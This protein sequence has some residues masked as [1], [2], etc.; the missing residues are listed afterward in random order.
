MREGHLYELGKGQPHGYVEVKGY[1]WVGD[2]SSAEIIVIEQ[3]IQMTPVLDCINHGSFFLHQ[4]Q[5]FFHGLVKVD[6]LEE[7]VEKPT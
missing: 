4:P 7:P 2:A 1:L 3:V 5:V 6:S